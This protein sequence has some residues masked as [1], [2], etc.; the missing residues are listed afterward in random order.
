MKNVF[1]FSDNCRDVAR[2]GP[3]VPMSPPPP[4]PQHP[5]SLNNDIS[6]FL[7]PNFPQVV[8]GD[9]ISIFCTFLAVT[10]RATKRNIL[11]A[12]ILNC[13]PPTIRNLPKQRYKKKIHG[14]LLQILS[15]TNDYPDLPTLLG[16][17][18]HV[19]NRQCFTHLLSCN[20]LNSVLVSFWLIFCNPVNLSFVFNVTFLLFLAFCTT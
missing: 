10:A 11:R 18:R 5:L 16:Q 6:N 19:Q 17:M 9:N 8:C 3:G 20:H 4:P 2:G 1:I 15:Q 7:H 14:C 13:I 12:K